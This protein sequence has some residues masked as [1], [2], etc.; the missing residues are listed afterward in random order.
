MLKSLHAVALTGA[1]IFGS[2]FTARAQDD[3]S[4]T[5]SLNR[6]VTVVPAPGNVTIDGQTNDWDLSAGAWSYN[7]PTLADKY[8]V[9]THLMHDANG[10]YFLAR[11]SDRSPLKNST[12]GKDFSKSWQ[13]DAYQARVIFDDKTPDEHQMHIN[14][15]FST[16]ENRPYM[17]VKHGGFGK[18]DSDATGPDRPELAARFGPTMEAF[19]GQIAMR[20]RDDGQGYNMEAF[21]PWKYLRLSGQ[22]LKAGEGFTF[23]WEAIWGT[24]DGTGG[25]VSRL[26]DGIK[27]EKANRI[28]MFRARNDWGRAVI[29]PRG[30]LLVSAEQEA[31]QA[32][33]LKRFV[34]YDTVGSIPIRYSLP[35]DRD[36]T[37]AIENAQGVR[38]RNLF[39]QFPRKAGQNTDYWDG[40]DDNG[41]PVTAG[42]YSAIIVDHRPV[43]L[44]FVNSVYNSAT[45]PWKTETGGASWGSNH[46]YPTTAATRGEVT[47]IGF[48]GTEGT[49]GILRCD[50]NG[51][52]LWADR[53]EILDAA[54]GEK[55]VYT[56]SRDVWVKQTVVRR[57][58]VKTGQITPFE[59]EKRTPTI[60]LGSG[61]GT[62]DASSIALSGG[63]LFVLVAGGGTTRKLLRLDPTTGATEAELPSNGLLALTDRDETLFGLFADGSVAR[64]GQNGAAT[65]KLFT[66]RGLLAPMRLGVSHDSKRFAISDVGTNQVFLFDAEGQK[67]GTLGAP[68]QAVNSQRPAGKFIETNFIRPLGL[69]FDAQNRLWVAE[70]QG[71]S[72]RVTNWSPQGQL[73]QSFWGSADYGGVDAF[74]ITFD[75]SR[76]IAHGVEFQLDPNPDVWKRPTREKP[77]VFHPE[78][79]GTR[80]FIFKYQNREYAVNTPGTLKPKGFMVALRDQSG[81]FVPRVRVSY[82]QGNT[83]GKAW[84]DRNLNGRED[85]GETVT[86]VAGKTHYWT[87][88]WIRPD[89]TIV[90]P[91]QQIFAPQGFTA[92]GVPLYDFLAPIAAN[93]FAPNFSASNSGTIVMDAAGNLSDGLQFRTVSGRSGQYP[94]RFKRWDAPAAQRGLIVAPFRTNG[95]VEGVPGV[96]SVTA[97]GGDRGEW[98]LMSL[99]GLYLSS[100]LQDTKGDVTLDETFVGQESFGGFLWRDETPGQNGRILVQ[101][102]G[103]SYR[104]MELKGLETTRRNTLELPVSAPQ[105]EEGARLAAAKNQAAPTEPTQL[106]IARV[107]QLPTV[108]VAPDIAPNAP[109]IAGAPDFTVSEAG[110][111]TRNF[112]A[113][114]AHDGTNLAVMFRVADP[115]PW[116]NAE[117]RF[118]HAFT[119]GDAV[120]LKLDVPGRGPIRVL[121]APLNG[122]DSAIFWQ[123]SAARPDNP[124]TYVVGNNVGNASRFDVVR[125]LTSARV[126]HQSGADGYSVLL[127]IPL[128]ELGVAPGELK[129]SVGVIFSD[130]SGTNRAARLYWHD[131]QTDLVSDV[132]SESRLE[133]GRFGRITVSP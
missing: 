50:P 49:T 65:Q 80:G 14:L 93:A 78:L 45:P 60:S 82:A 17:I 106:Q 11:F 132:P 113:A 30:R 29:A 10:V 85:A 46:G 119:G 8:S 71:N 74:P 100:I 94:N 34:N 111:P 116:K 127:T 18:N 42:R 23:G 92:H 15:F 68:Y 104:I 120:D 76:F 128:A 59:D 1:L 103:I 41:K 69:D 97:I 86:G 32:A 24:G 88:G 62:E 124:Q 25:V 40:L 19:G 54:I 6:E 37:I 117:G 36:V 21:W 125:R 56:L 39:G 129:G 2:H 27:S 96:G 48:T 108:P 107:A 122:Q 110:N 26:A 70:A 4:A 126:V 91:D 115:N 102:G 95:V 35:D 31:L 33:R 67:I 57:L 105:I 58:D 79:T 44:K 101:L 131:K 20:A 81:V 83:P 109:L 87:A 43:E 3:T 47:I 121:A 75:S 66:A 7:N 53:N 133:V 77:L 61:E 90:T 98:F 12:Q 114:L 64:L 5:M 16:P 63:K 112:R 123:K 73:L 22:P 9:W 99:D 84:T 38:V 13:G 130:P 72:K 118:T 51:R 52:I 55:Y 28:F 89:L